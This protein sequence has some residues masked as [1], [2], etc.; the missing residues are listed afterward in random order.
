MYAAVTLAALGCAPT[1]KPGTDRADAARADAPTARDVIADARADVGAPGDVPSVADVPVT[2]PLQASCPDPGERGCGLVS[3]PGGVFTM[4]H[5]ST[6]LVTDGS[7]EQPNIRV[8]GFVL[9]AHE[10]TVARFRRF[11]AEAQR[12]PPVTSVRYPAGDL[13]VAQGLRTPQT[14]VEDPGCNWSTFVDRELHPINCV[15]WYT[16]MAFCVWDGGRLPTDAEWEYAARGSR[17]GRPAQRADVPVGR[18]RPQPD[19]RPRA[20]EPHGLRG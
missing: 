17:G 11:W 3:V 8:G 10:V 5:T 4:G 14:R 20:L 12:L 7:P 16:A 19:V 15:D 13:P 1:L 6:A 9:D 18:S 2:R